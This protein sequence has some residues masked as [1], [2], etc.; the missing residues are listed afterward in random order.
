[1]NTCAYFFFDE[2]HPTYGHLCGQPAAKE[3]EFLGNSV[4]V[5]EEHAPDM[6]CGGALLLAGLHDT[7]YVN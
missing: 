2:D 1:M 5:C 7:G 6:E 3:V 4:S